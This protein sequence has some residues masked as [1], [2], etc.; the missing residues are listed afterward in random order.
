MI[1]VDTNIVLRLVLDDD[2][3]QV[4]AARALMARAPIFVSLGVLLETGWVLQSRYR[5]PRL[6]V[7]DALALVVSL[8]RIVVARRTLALWA[9]DRYR[10]GADLA[11]MVHLA[12]AAKV[13][14][15]A[16][17]DRRIVKDAGPDAPVVIE[18]LA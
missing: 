11:D 7:A 1:A 16:T 2:E 4:Q 9:I 17:F 12:S 15:F 10:D 8:D 3:A 14:A 5:M 13:G 18:T 6:E